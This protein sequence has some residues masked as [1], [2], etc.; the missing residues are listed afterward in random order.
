MVPLQRLCEAMCPTIF[1][2]WTV[3]LL[4]G[5]GMSCASPGHSFFFLNFVDSFISSYSC[6]IV[7][8]LHVV[9]GSDWEIVSVLITTDQR[10]DSPS[11]AL[12]FLAQLWQA[13]GLRVCCVRRALVCGV[14][15]SVVV[16]LFL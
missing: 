2:G 5:L 4:V 15:A 14:F 7:E 12:E 16:C 10:T 6:L 3:V 13:C 1:Y 8:S 11:Q 9:S